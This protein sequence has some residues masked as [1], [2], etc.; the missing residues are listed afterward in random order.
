M[1]TRRKS[2]RH[3]RSNQGEHDEGSE[4]YVPGDFKS[5]LGTAAI[6]FGAYFATEYL[7][8]TIA[9]SQSWGAKQSAV[10]AGAV[11]GSAGYIVK[12]DWSVV[13]GLGA[14]LGAVLPTLHQATFGTTGPVSGLSDYGSVPQA[15]GAAR[16]DG[17]GMITG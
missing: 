7:G 9:T 10:L 13:I 12:R 2:K 17:L 8:K 16:L 11:V 4:Q 15:T 5:I 1:S 14:L 3:R 6:T